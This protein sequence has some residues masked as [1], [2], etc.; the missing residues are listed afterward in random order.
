MFE[1]IF[2]DLSTVDDFNPS[3]RFGDPISGFTDAIMDQA[4]FKTARLGW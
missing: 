1:H 4:V 2:G 3:S